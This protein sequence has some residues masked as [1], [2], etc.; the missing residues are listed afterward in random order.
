GG[1]S[2]HIDRFIN[3]ASFVADVFEDLQL[4][5]IFR[6]PAAEAVD[7]QT[8]LENRSTTNIIVIDT[9]K[10]KIYKTSSPYKISESATEL[11][12]TDR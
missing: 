6:Y 12:I 2:Y 10:Q 7:D 9:D 11:R 3:A 8:H 1:K 5:K 4:Q